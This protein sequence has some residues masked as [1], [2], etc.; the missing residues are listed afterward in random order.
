M[1][2]GHQEMMAYEYINLGNN[3]YKKVKN[4]KYLGPLLT[5]QNYIHEEIKRRFQAGN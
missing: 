1:E 5:N 2:V 3:S 4:F